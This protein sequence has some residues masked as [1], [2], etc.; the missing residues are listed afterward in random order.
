MARAYETKQSRI[1]PPIAVEG[2]F[3]SSLIQH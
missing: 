2:I 3:E 1:L